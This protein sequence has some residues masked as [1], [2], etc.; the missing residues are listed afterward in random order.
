M[1][2]ASG[3]GI[4][5]VVRISKEGIDEV[6]GESLPQG[7]RVLRQ[8]DLEASQARATEV[9]KRVQNNPI[10]KA[11]AGALRQV[12]DKITNVQEQSQEVKTTSEQTQAQMIEESATSGGIS[13]TPQE[14]VP[15]VIGTS[16]NTRASDFRK[17]EEESMK[18]IQQ[19]Y[20]Y[21]EPERKQYSDFE[22]AWIDFKK[23]IGVE[24]SN[25]DAAEIP[26]EGGNQQIQPQEKGVL[27]TL[28]E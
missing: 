18:G 12:N 7:E 10:A 11:V 8:G 27:D 14:F 15:P 24:D 23:L 17:L 19:Q 28:G 3:E 5:R 6:I 26:I 13:E 25:A 21:K 16:S 4:N 20:S 2:I 1:I 22:L 9:T